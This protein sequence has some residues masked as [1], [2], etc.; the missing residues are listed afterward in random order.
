MSERSGSADL[1]LLLRQGIA[2]S[3]PGAPFVAPGDV[4]WYRSLLLWL[5]MSGRELAGTIRA[6]R[7]PAPWPAPFCRWGYSSALATCSPL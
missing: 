6:E 7:R 2:L 3:P 1:G 5:P 4:E